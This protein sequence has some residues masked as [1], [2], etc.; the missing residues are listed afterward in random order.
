MS[1]VPGPA[2]LAVRHRMYLR[3]GVSMN[4]ATA[5]VVAAGVAS[6]LTKLTVA[7]VSVAVAAL[8]G[9]RPAG[10]GTVLIAVVIA[11]PIVAVVAIVQR[12]AA[13]GQG[14]TGMVMR[15]SSSILRGRWAIILL[16]NA[17]AV[18]VSVT[19]LLVS[20]RTVGVD[21]DEVTWYAV[22]AAYGVVQLASLVPVSVG[23]AGVAELVLIGA[24]GRQPELRDGVAAGVLVYRS[25]TF[26]AP[27]PVGAVVL[28]VTYWRPSGSASA[29][30]L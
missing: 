24:L 28:A 5:S 19:L 1:T 16:G 11:V 26:L 30:H 21:A 8:A 20:L 6:S 22:F 15:E 10:G 12:R 2:D 29:A 7:V 9:T 13:Q 4:R 27:L 17:G 18:M 23:N 14:R 3:W 25:A